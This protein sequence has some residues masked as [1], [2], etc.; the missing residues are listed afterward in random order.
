[1]PLGPFYRA[2]FSTAAIGAIVVGIVAW[3]SRDSTGAVPLVGYAGGTAVW[4]IAFLLAGL[5]PGRA[6]STFWVT[7]LYAGVVTS[8]GNVFLFTLVYTG[9]QHLLTR[10]TV[11]LVAVEPLLVVIATATNDSH[12]LFWRSVT[13][14]PTTATGLA[15]VRGPGF[16]MH[17]IYTYALTVVTVGLILQFAYRRSSLYRRQGAALIVFILAVLAT[18]V[19][20]VAGLTPVDVTLIGHTVGAAALTLAVVEYDLVDLTPVAR[21]TVYNTLEE[22]VVVVD[23]DDTVVDC[24]RAARETF[25]VGEEYVGL[26]AT[27]FFEPVAADTLEAFA[28]VSDTETEVTVTLDGQQRHFAVS[29][30]SLGEDRQRGRVVVLHEITERKRR[31]QHLRRQNERLDRFASVVSHDLRNPLNAARGWFEVAADD[32]EDEHAEAVSRNLD[33]ME[34]MIDD[35]LEMS[36]AGEV[37]EDPDPVPLADLVTES[38]ETVRPEHADLELRVADSVSVPADDR[39]LQQVFENLFRNAVEHNDSS[40]TVTV[41]TREDD[42]GFLVADDGDGIPEDDRETV[43][44]HGYTTNDEGTGFGLSIVVDIVEAHGWE[45]S[46]SDAADGGARFDVTGVDIDR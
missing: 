41:D 15:F 36:R 3:R 38:W 40:V 5:D 28:D 37:V 2:V 21:E 27:E 19:A 25:G 23:A 6:W 39:R 14:D 16:W 8:V 22:G 20:W 31:E 13:T 7:V 35:I 17:T 29:I 1:M 18:N 12:Q 45:I 46:V 34:R 11:S 30:S 10:R 24:N 43:L 4:A 32:V 26:S 33:R 42:R 9:R 44:E